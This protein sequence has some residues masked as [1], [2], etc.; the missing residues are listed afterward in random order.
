MEKQRLLEDTIANQERKK[1]KKTQTNFSYLK[2]LV[3]VFVKQ[4]NF[5]ANVV[6]I[7]ILTPLHWVPSKVHTVLKMLA[8]S[9]SHKKFPLLQPVFLMHTQ[10]V[11]T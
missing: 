9:S 5:P 1:K 8:Q 6:L 7:Q 3:L 4:L 2:G 10:T 11:F